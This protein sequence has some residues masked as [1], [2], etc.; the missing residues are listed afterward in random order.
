MGIS[1]LPPGKPVEPSVMQDMA[2]EWWFR[3]VRMQDLVGE[4]RAVVCILLNRS[5]FSAML[6]RLGV[7]I[8][9]P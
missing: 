5:P 2:L 1:P 9:L 3:P 7:F 8:G 4:Q 6:S